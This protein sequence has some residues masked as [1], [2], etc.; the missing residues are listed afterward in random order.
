MPCSGAKLLR[1][2]DSINTSERSS[3]WVNSSYG[4]GVALGLIT[5]DVGNGVIVGIVV[6][7]GG[8]DSGCGMLFQNAMPMKPIEKIITTMSA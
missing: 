4:T 3:C 5:A 7:V 6:A 2:V 1:G 8:G